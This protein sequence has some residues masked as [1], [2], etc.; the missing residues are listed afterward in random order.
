MRTV[1]TIGKTGVRKDENYKVK[2][3][4]GHVSARGT[5]LYKIHEHAIRARVYAMYSTG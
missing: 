1:Q 2:V 5:P 4:E 3:H